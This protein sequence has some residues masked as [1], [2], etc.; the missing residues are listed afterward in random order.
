MRTRC[1]RVLELECT[2]QSLHIIAQCNRANAAIGRTDQQNTA[3][4]SRRHVF[5]ACSS[6]AT[7]IRCRR[8]PEALVGIAVNSAAAPVTG[9]EGSAAHGFAALELALE[10][11]AVPG[12]DVLRGCQPDDLLEFPLEMI[13]T[14]S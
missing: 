7:T 8:H 13:R 14:E 6:P 3:R 1:C 12:A 11:F 4:C 5:D 9:A 2:F 10:P